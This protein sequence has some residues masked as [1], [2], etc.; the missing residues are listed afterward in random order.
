M[1]SV[2]LPFLLS[3][4]WYNSRRGKEINLLRKWNQPV[5]QGLRLH[6]NLMRQKPSFHRV[7]ENSRSQRL[8]R[9]SSHQGSS[10]WSQSIAF[11]GIE[12]PLE[13]AS[14]S[15]RTEEMNRFLM[16]TNV[17]AKLLPLGLLSTV[18]LAHSFPIGTYWSV[19][20][21]PM[22]MKSQVKCEA[23]G[24]FHVRNR[25]D[26]IIFPPSVC[27]WM[28]CSISQ[29]RLSLP[30]ASLMDSSFAS[31]RKTMTTKEFSNKNCSLSLSIHGDQSMRDL[32]QISSLHSKNLRNQ[33]CSGR[34]ASDAE[35]Y[36]SVSTKMLRT[37]WTS[38][39]FRIAD[40]WMSNEILHQWL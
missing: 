9:Y 11:A 12:D 26:V 30:R 23:S 1:R 8:I 22:T 21:V 16:R 17:L 38:K 27:K 3:V 14:D 20:N 37:E 18:T 35:R 40:R 4:P 13:K 36:F 5:G 32:L 34:V 19:E 10:R 7:F 39:F 6:S 28:F 2:S 33:R 24:R 31:R 25:P 29:W 15:N